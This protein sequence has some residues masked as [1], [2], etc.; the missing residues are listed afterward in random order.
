MIVIVLYTLTKYIKVST[1]KEVSV[2]LTKYNLR[3]IRA[4]FEAKS[5]HGGDIYFII[6][7]SSS[8]FSPIKLDSLF[9]AVISTLSI[10]K[11]PK[12]S[13]RSSSF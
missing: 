7:Y 2:E 13:E 11:P 5:A 9:R 6:I 1:V 4:L 3:K 10:T 12:Y 8:A